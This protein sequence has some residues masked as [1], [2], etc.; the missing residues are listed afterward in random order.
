MF[1]WRYQSLSAVGDLAPI[2]LGRVFCGILPTNLIMY[3]HSEFNQEELLINK[4]RLAEETYTCL[5]CHQLLR[6]P[7]HCSKCKSEY[8]KQCALKWKKENNTCPLRCMAPWII[9]ESESKNIELKCPVGECCDPISPENFEEHLNECLRENL[10]KR[11]L[12]T[13]NHQLTYMSDARSLICSDCGKTS[14]CR[15][16]CLSCKVIGATFLYYYCCKCRIPPLTKKF[17]PVGHEFA[18]IIPKGGF[19]CNICGQTSS[20]KQL[21]FG[22]KHCNFAIC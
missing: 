18:H 10:K 13:K 3:M 20:K 7:V 17:C 6:Y 19:V 15:S 12:C 4:E 14:L 16:V 1:V 21:S 8:C 5:I 2:I 11:Y 22:D 9:Q